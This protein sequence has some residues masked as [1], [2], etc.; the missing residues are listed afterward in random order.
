[1]WYVRIFL[2]ISAPLS[3][4][5]IFR[6]NL[7]SA[8]SISLESTFNAFLF[9]LM[10]F[11]PFFGVAL[12]ALF[13]LFFSKLITCMSSDMEWIWFLTLSSHSPLEH[14]PVLSLLSSRVFCA[15]APPPP[16]PPETSPLSASFLILPPFSHFIFWF[17]CQEAANE[18][19]PRNSVPGILMQS[20]R[21]LVSQLFI[22][23]HE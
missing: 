5:N 4:I 10:S 23:R 12:C 19:Y 22:L 9:T 7:I 21:S 14:P 6:M 3:L 1:M 17:W 2:K 18:R 13:L 16:P 15:P 20:T 11:V 8:G